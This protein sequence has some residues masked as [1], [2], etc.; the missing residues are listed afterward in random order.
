MT[1]RAEDFI[2]L[3]T[4]DGMYMKGVGVVD[5]MALEINVPWL[6]EHGMRPGQWRYD[7]I[8]AG[9]CWSSWTGEDAFPAHEIDAWEKIWWSHQRYHALLAAGLIHPAVQELLALERCGFPIGYL[10]GL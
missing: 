7:W 6:R 3:M 4:L 1:I 5:G 9:P 8:L 10:G 2:P